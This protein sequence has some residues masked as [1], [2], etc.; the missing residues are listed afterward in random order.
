MGVPDSAGRA[1]AHSDASVRG[2]HA[3]VALRVENL[4]VAYRVGS[5]DVVAVR[6]LSFDVRKGEVLAI[7]GE[8]GSGKTTV[9]LAALSYLPRAGRIVSGNVLFNGA[10]ILGLSGGE[11]RK[12][13][14]R[15]IAHV[16]QDP[17][18][19][20]NPA[21]RVSTQ[22][23]EGMRAQLGLDRQEA[24]QRAKRLL[25]EVQ[26][27]EPAKVLA[28]YAHQ[29]SGGMQ[30]RVCIAMAL[31][32]DPDLIVMDE[33]TTGLDA[34]TEAAIFAILRE[35]VTRRGLSVLFI[36]H[37]LAA[38]HSLADRVLVMYAGRGLELGPAHEVFD[39]P[40]H[41]YTALLLRSLPTMRSMDGMPIEI[42]WQ[43]KAF[44][45][46]GCPFS[47]RCDMATPACNA[48]VTLAPV[49]EDR[50]S[51]CV[52]AEDLLRSVGSRSLRTTLDDTAPNT[53]S[54]PVTPARPLLQVSALDHVYGSSM[55][56]FGGSGRKTFDDLSFTIG[57]GE[58]LALIGESGS[59]KTT[60]AR[61][62]VGLETPLRG[63]LAFEGFD[64]A[65]R[66]RRPRNV[67]RR[68]Q[69]VF[70]NIAGSLHPGKLVRSILSRPYELYERRTPQRQELASLMQSVGLKAEYLEKRSPALSGGERQRVALARA[71][72]SAPAL[73]VL[74]EAFS[75][76]DVSMKVKVMRLL[77]DH[78]IKSG[79][80][81]LL[82][83]HD[84]PIVRFMADRVAVLYRGWLCEVGPRRVIEAPP[85]HPYT[86]ALM[87]AALELEGLRPSAVSME[88][89]ATPD[90]AATAISDTG[91]RFRHRCPR[92]LGSICDTTQ[93]PV[94]QISNGHWL[95]CHIPTSELK[96]LQS[97]EW[98]QSRA[99]AVGVV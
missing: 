80:S 70:Q 88:R 21:L 83:T 95:A 51:A 60:F 8:S 56:G 5:T 53:D 73:V 35:L 43:G 91:C 40:S 86:E 23:T 41:R 39:R 26:I 85:M 13:Y 58:V 55:L 99:E 54:D 22:L 42:P 10:S 90:R 31:A 32:C 44:P 72:S 69:M 25:E 97:R 93:P 6:N 15:R 47:D 63:R 12:L 2:G 34:A 61:C 74:D 19:S 82:I 92:Y 45:K 68:L 57:S 30:Q 59:G 84:L 78:R 96:D 79:M 17:S 9:A 87:W 18:A 20:L 14:G 98:P 11:K 71:T 1:T 62:V 38:V 37:N 46:V 52:Y 28:S 65:K 49:A 27:A 29:L 64:L 76:L 75:A 77:Q 66:G 48:E 16:S 89:A 3:A 24:L 36:S 81:M 94:Q 50:T 67:A 33:P 7:V 4:G